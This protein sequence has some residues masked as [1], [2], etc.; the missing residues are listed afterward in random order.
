[1]KGG[2]TQ[3][4]FYM[5]DFKVGKTVLT[6]LWD[7][8]NSYIEKLQMPKFILTIPTCVH[9]IMYIVYTCTRTHNLYLQLHPGCGNMEERK[10]V[11]DQFFLL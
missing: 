3:H 10:Q 4:M 8:N 1:M 7:N 2:E 5:N 9:S 11:L 6:S